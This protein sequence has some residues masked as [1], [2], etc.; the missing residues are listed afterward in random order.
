MKKRYITLLNYFLDALQK[1]GKVAAYLSL[2]L[3]IVKSEVKSPSS[4]CLLED[5]I[6]YQ[7]ICRKK[8]TAILLLEHAL[9]SD[10]KSK[11]T[12][13]YSLWSFLFTF[14]PLQRKKSVNKN[15]LNVKKNQRKSKPTMAI[16]HSYETH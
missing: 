2:L 4:E 3:S 6:E 11:F 12:D 16:V 7:T 9:H 1:H 15:T 10:R 5:T 13:F 8:M 14:C